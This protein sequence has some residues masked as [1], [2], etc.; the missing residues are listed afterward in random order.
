MGMQN[1]DFRKALLGLIDARLEERRVE[2]GTV[3][4]SFLS[5]GTGVPVVLL[6][7]GGAGAVTWYPSIG[8]LA[9]EFFVIA[10]DIVGYGESEKPEGAYDRP[11]FSKWLG[12]FLDAVGISRAHVVGLSQGGAIAL[13]FALD[14]PNRVDKLVLV[15][16]GALGAKP[17]T[18][19]LLT[20]LWMNVAPSRLANWFFS[21]F[22]LSNP[23]ARD[24][25]HG[26]YSIEVLKKV[27]GKNAFSRGRGAAVSEIGED[28]LRT[29]QPETCLIWGDEDRLF[30]VE[31]GERAARII[32]N[33]RLCR[34]QKAGHLCLMDQPEAF[35]EAL[36]SFLRG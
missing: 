7:G 34:I 18:Q 20:M 14:H 31:T 8:A 28:V 25:N 3:G 12:E 35:N 11:F 22:L 16:S 29:I 30:P 9:K 6:H 4:T 2:A 23:A 21:R 27:G 15:N 36:L 17:S 33:A 13:Q 26:F 10:P 5:A 32:P 1:H 19:A 24:R